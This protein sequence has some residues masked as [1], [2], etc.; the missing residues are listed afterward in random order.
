MWVES[1][2]DQFFIFATL[3]YAILMK[4]QSWRFIFGSF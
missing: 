4:R 2:I 3:L 1:S